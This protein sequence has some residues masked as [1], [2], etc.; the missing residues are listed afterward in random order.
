MHLTQE[1]EH[2]WWAGPLGLAAFNS[3][4]K[5][6]GNSCVKYTVFI[7]PTNKRFINLNLVLLVNG[8]EY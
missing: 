3:L 7:V 1:D 4:T 2:C 8:S 6:N 5:D